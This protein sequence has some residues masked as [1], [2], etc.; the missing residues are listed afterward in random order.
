MLEIIPWA[1]PISKAAYSQL[2][3]SLCEPLIAFEIHSLARNGAWGCVGGV[4]LVGL[5][6]KK[7]K[8]K[9]TCLLNRPSRVLRVWL[10]QSNVALKLLGVRSTKVFH[11]SAWIAV[12]VRELRFP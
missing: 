5:R 7:K 9:K 10:S 1:G 11:G 3:D 4:K 2:C 12:P 6:K 8:Q